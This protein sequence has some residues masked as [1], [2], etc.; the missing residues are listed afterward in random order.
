MNAPVKTTRMT[1]AENRQGVRVEV[2]AVYLDDIPK[3]MDKMGWTVSAQLMRRW[4]ATKPAWVMPQ[5][6]RD[7]EHPSKMP[8]NY[9][10][11]PKSQ[12][13]EQ[14]VKMAWALNFDQVKAVRA[15]L[16]GSW[17]S[18]NGIDVLRTRLKHAGWKTGQTLR[19]G[20]KH[21]S[22]MQLDLESQVNALK[23]GSAWDTLNDYFGAIFKASLKV[24][25]VG[26]AYRSLLTGKN[27]FEV[28]QLG[29]Y[30]RDTYDFNASWY[31]DAFMG[32]GVWSKERVLTKAQMAEY[33]ALSSRTPASLM[34]RHLRYP[35]FVQVENADFRR[36]QQKR[37]EG[38]DFFVFSDVLWEAYRGPAIEL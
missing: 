24:A 23:L 27:L 2:D 16:Q 12:V 32:L 1:P 6:W 31:D 38:G 29:F 18:P 5:E 19:L 36:W 8:I 20:N 17:N 30:I 21:M 4:F 3:A 15:V 25:V 34:A 10:L 28:E 35:Y 14:I 11:L 37:N 33:K 22:A 7:G 13:D 26:K 9:T